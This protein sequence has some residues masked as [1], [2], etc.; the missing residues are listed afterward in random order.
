LTTTQTFTPP[1]DDLLA[2]LVNARVGIGFHFRHSV[3]TGENPLAPNLATL[4]APTLLPAA[5]RKHD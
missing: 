2:T 4:V 1:V 5:G 3:L